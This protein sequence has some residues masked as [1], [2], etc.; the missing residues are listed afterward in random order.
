MDWN[1]EA[2]LAEL[3][4][5]TDNNIGEEAGVLSDVLKANTTLTTLDLGC[6]QAQE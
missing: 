5:K 1:N 2:H 3:T 4:L 6:E